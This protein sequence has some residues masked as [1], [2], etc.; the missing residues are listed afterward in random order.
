M[1]TNFRLELIDPPA[2]HVFIY[3]LDSGREREERGGAD[4]ERSEHGEEMYHVFKLQ[5]MKISIS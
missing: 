2:K 4:E 1:S 5:F 3:F